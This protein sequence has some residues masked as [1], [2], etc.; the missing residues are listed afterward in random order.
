MWASRGAD[1][2]ES[3][4]RCGRVAVQMWASRGAD[5][6]ESRSRCGRVAEQMWAS[7]GADVGE[8]PARLRRDWVSCN[9]QV[10]TT[11]AA[12]S[13]RKRSSLSC[14][15]PR[16][17]G[18]PTE[19]GR[20]IGRDAGEERDREEGTRGEGGMQGMQQEGRGGEGRGGEARGGEARRGDRRK[21][22]KPAPGGCAD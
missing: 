16:P 14:K 2:G 12:L 8:S 18:S 10:S 5:V 13:M 6:G 19:R 3:R 15:A 20:G 22:A 11:F 1:V 17:E 21:R 7:R 9:A 4:C